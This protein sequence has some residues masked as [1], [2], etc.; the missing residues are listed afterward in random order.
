MKGGEQ[1]WKDREISI[2]ASYPSLSQYCMKTHLGTSL[3]IFVDLV[4]VGCREDGKVGQS[5]KGDGVR[6][7]GVSGSNGVAGDGSS[8]DRVG[9]LGSEEETVTSDDLVR[10]KETSASLFAVSS[11]RSNALCARCRE[12]LTA[13]AVKVGPLKTSRRARVWSEGCL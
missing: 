13:S 2:R 5:V 1:R 12:R 10:R 6:R 8:G 7:G 4:V 11:A 3:N 9:R